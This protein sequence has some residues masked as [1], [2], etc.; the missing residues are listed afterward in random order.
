MKIEV[1]FIMNFPKN[2]RYTV[3][4]E[5]HVEDVKDGIWITIYKRSKGPRKMVIYFQPLF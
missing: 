2:R 1:S 4:Y 3:F 5:L